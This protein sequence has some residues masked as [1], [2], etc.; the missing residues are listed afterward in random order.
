MNIKVECYCGYQV[1]ETPRRILF[2]SRTVEVLKII[3]RW[4]SPDHRYFKIRGSDNGEYIIRYDTQ[5]QKWELTFYRQQAQD[6]I[7]MD[8]TK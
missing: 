3:D 1:E 6:I 4:L 2:R 7:V 5:K 8:K